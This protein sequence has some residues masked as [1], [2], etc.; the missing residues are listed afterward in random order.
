MTTS[1]WSEIQFIWSH[2]ASKYN[3]VF[4][5]FETLCQTLL[6]TVSEPAGKLQ[7]FVSG[8]LCVYL[9]C[10]GAVWSGGGLSVRLYS[11]GVG[12]GPLGS[13]IQLL[14]VAVT[15]SAAE[16]RFAKMDG[17]SQKEH[18]CPG[19]RAA[20]VRNIDA[21]PPAPSSGGAPHKRAALLSE[22]PAQSGQ[23]GGVV[24]G[25]R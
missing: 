6:Q 3:T 5:G 13:G 2:K 18:A 15:Q 21:A 23:G 19:R 16:P 20:P 14:E 11:A 12:S 4:L 7:M 1:E 25:A 17:A 8:S 10:F 22:E 9:T 24:A